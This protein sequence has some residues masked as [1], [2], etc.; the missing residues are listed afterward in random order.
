MSSVTADNAVLHALRVCGFATTTRLA[1]YLRVPDDHAEALATGCAAEG[2]ARYR[3]G[4]IK[5]WLLTDAGRERHEQQIASA[6]VDDG[7]QERVMAGYTV[8]VGHNRDL[9]QICTAWQLRTLPDGT[10]EVNDHSDREY[11]DGVVERLATH[12]RRCDSMFIQLREGLTR[13]DGYRHRLDEALERLSTGEAA[14]FA[15]PMSASYHCVWMELHQDL[16]ITLGRER[17]EADGH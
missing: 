10:T 15:T 11:D 8:F 7:W 3:D 5:G 12:H 13:F 1:E 16:L 6:R 14:A 4:R 9:K 2:L 17:D